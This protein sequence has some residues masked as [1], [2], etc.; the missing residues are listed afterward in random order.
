VYLAYNDGFSARALR[1]LLT[2]IEASRG[3]IEKA[4][5]KFFG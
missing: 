3:R 4:W 5:S 1:E 2:L